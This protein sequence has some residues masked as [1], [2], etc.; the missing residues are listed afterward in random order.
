MHQAGPPLC[1]ALD[2]PA[3][4]C[5]IQ[6]AVAHH[7][8][9]ERIWLR[10]ASASVACQI[11]SSAST[12]AAAHSAVR[13]TRLFQLLLGLICSVEDKRTSLKTEVEPQR[14]Q[15]IQERGNSRYQARLFRIE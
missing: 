12:A 10:H 11:S 1:H 5:W 15:L 3:V 14:L 13:Y 7:R 6:A 4:H 2:L 9:R 8:G